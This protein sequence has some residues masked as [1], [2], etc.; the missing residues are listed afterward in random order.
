MSVLTSSARTVNLGGRRNR[1]AANLDHF[2]PDKHSTPKSSD[3]QL[4]GESPQLR[5][6]PDLL[7]HSPRSDVLSSSLDVEKEQERLE[8]LVL[9]EE[10]Q[11][12]WNQPRKIV[13]VFRDSKSTS[14]Y[15]QLKDDIKTLSSRPNA[16]PK[17]S[18]N[19]SP[20][21]QAGQDL[22]DDDDDDYEYPDGPTVDNREEAQPN[23]AGDQAYSMPDPWS[24]IMTF[25]PY[26]SGNSANRQWHSLSAK[27]SMCSERSSRLDPHTYQ[28]YTAGLLHSSGKSE[29]F[30]NLQKHYTVLERISELERKRNKSLKKVKRPKSWHSDITAEEEELQDL[31]LE[32]DEAKKNREFFS[33][34]GE[35]AHKHWNPNAD[36]GLMQKQKSLQ[37][38]KMKYRS[39][40]PYKI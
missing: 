24:K 23:M 1:L 27:S 38:L 14:D 13:D 16:S 6:R 40:S 18:Q 9:E 30:L 15:L 20:R 34:K 35:H 29:K 5:R 31:Y 3:L 8:R 4:E 39:K 26:E 28:S 19:N 11:R 17:H 2:T 36:K 12:E 21:H 33:K 22:Y 10:S 7:P 37:D 25:E 32:L